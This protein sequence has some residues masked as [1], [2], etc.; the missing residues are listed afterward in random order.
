MKIGIVT[1]HDSS[2]LGSYLQALSMQ[3]IVK[4]NGDEPY[5]IKT[6]SSFTTLCLF[7]G[8]NNSRPVRS[9]KT[10]VKFAIKSVMKYK[11]TREKY[12]KYRTYK[13]DWEKYDNIIS[14]RK[15]RKIG[16]DVLLLGSDEIWNVNQPAFQNPLL[17]GIGIPA[18]KK[19]GYAISVG[20]ALSD[21][22]ES[23]PQ[24]I[25]GIADLDSIWVRD[26]HTKEILQHYNIDTTGKICDPTL[27]VDI[28]KYMKPLEKVKVPNED[29]IVV[30][31]YSV[32]ENMK[33][34][35]KQFAANNKL[36]TVAVSLPQPWC[37]EYLNC[38]PLEFGMVLDKAKYVY[39]TTFHGTIFSMLYHSKV[40]VHPVNFKVKEVLK[41]LGRENAAIEEKVSYEQFEKIINKEIDYSTVEEEISKMKV[42]SSNIY[43]NIVG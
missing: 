28:R 32:D 39:T 36:K 35:I 38:S 30:Y 43:K 4:N 41:L 27:Q 22:F 8:Y 24:L 25:K 31:S 9:L 42:D 2:N 13:K 6:R 3:E 15:A 11:E 7:L 21:K 23:Y 16:L 19:Y 40:A 1:V 18:T 5:F 37:D 17:Y 12:K 29:Y 33:H 26:Y 14:V 20:N 34:I 10:F